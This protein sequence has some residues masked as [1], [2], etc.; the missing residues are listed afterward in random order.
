MSLESKTENNL[1][2][3]LSNKVVWIQSIHAKELSVLFAKLSPRVCDV[4]TWQGHN[5]VKNGILVEVFLC[6]RTDAWSAV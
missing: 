1:L 2:P 6:Q 4:R 3:L 5:D